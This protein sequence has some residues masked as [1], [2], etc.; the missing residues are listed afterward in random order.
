SSSAEIGAVGPVI[1]AIAAGS[2]RAVGPVRGLP[3][4][5]AA[6][7]RRCEV[8]RISKRM[9][10]VTFAF[11]GGHGKGQ[12]TSHRWSTSTSLRARNNSRCPLFILPFSSS[13]S[14][15]PFHPPLLAGGGIRGGQVYGARTRSP[16]T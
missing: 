14:S 15:S 1:A 13:F 10:N 9:L 11:G 12:P 2:P 5:Q 6:G 8:T 7:E 16:P 3:P 4:L